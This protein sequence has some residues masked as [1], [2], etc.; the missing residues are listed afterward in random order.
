MSK[1]IVLSFAL[2]FICFSAHAELK[3]TYIGTFEAAVAQGTG[4]FAYYNEFEGAVNTPHKFLITKTRSKYLFRSTFANG[5]PGI[6]VFLR[7]KK[8]KY[9]SRNLGQSTINGIDCNQDVIVSITE[10][11]S[12]SFTGTSSEYYNCSG[13]FIILEAKL[14]AKR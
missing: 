8:N 4:V 6:R 11:S 10:K 14:K 5:S 2:F 3:G 9:T 12:K 7:K 1:A 13:S